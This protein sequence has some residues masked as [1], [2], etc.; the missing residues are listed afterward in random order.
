MP[1]SM[2]QTFTASPAERGH[3]E[4]KTRAPWARRLDCPERKDVFLSSSNGLCKNPCS[5][6]WLRSEGAHEIPGALVADR[7]VSSR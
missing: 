4:P 5:A 6:S 2:R 7:V 1:L 3:L